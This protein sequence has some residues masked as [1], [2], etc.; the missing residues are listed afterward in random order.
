MSARD[1]LDRRLADWMTET[2]SDPPPAGRFEQAMKATARRRPRPPW[3]ATVGSDWVGTTA[4]RRVEWGWPSGRRELVAAVLVALLVAAALVGA[5]LVGAQLLRPERNP[6]PKPASN[7]WIAFGV[8]NDTP[9]AFLGD[10]DIFLVGEKRGARRVVGTDSDTLD[11]VCPAFSA[12][13]TRLAFGEGQGTSGT[14]YRDAALVIADIDANGIVSGAWTIPVG[15]PFAPP[16]PIWSPDGRR[17]AFVVPNV[18]N[19][20]DQQPAGAGDVWVVTL[21]GGQVKVLPGVWA[22]DLD[23]A[24]DGSRL[25]IA[26]GHPPASVPHTGGPL[27]LYS[28]ASEEVSPLLGAS[29][30]ISL[31]WS[32]DGSR[33]AYQRIRTP[34]TP[35]YG[36]I[37]AGS[38]EQEIWTIDADGRGGTL[39][40]EPFDVNQGM[41]PVWSPAGD[42]IVYQRVCSAHPPGQTGPCLE[43]HDVV[44]LTPGTTVSETKPVGSEVVLPFVHVDRADATSFWWPFQVSWSPDGQKLFYVAWGDG[45]LMGLVAVDVDLSSPPI[46]LHEA[47]DFGGGA[48][49]ISGGGLWIRSW[50]SWGR[51]PGT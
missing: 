19:S 43:Q 42:R 6:L 30:V 13:A 35:A 8:G 45:D 34:A 50:S 2:A 25:A 32:P 49:D 16:C 15:V 31:A 18:L 26:G 4:P 10:H 40:T 27:L 20:G 36:G 11:Q 47:R 41:G 21:G 9:S 37:V 33:I 1:E 3:L 44:L 46:V 12:D 7:G 51:M 23:W 14:G 38:E 39:Q 28:V 22:S 17:I 48:G 5:A 24:P 29:G